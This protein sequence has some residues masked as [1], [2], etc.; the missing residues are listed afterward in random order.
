MFSGNDVVTERKI[1]NTDFLDSGD[2][3]A[4]PVKTVGV[5]RESG[6]H[7]GTVA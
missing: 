4:A 7:V 2:G 6:H 5:G 1:R 3:I